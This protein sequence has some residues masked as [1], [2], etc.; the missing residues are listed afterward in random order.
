MANGFHTILLKIYLNTSLT[1]TFQRSLDKGAQIS[2][3][4]MPSS[5]RAIANQSEA[6]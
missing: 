3:Q 4:T 5:Y 2:D 6:Y 1:P